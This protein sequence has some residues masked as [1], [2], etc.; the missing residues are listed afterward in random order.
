MPKYLPF[1]LSLLIIS[2]SDSP[3]ADSKKISVF[4]VPKLLTLHKKEVLEA[5]GTPAATDSLSDIQRSRGIEETLDFRRG[6]YE[7][8]LDFTPSTGEVLRG[9]ISL[10]NQ[11]NVD[12]YGLDSL[13]AAGNLDSL[14]ANYIAK[15]QDVQENG[16]TVYTG[17]HIRSLNE[18]GKLIK[19]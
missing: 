11:A 19:K 13:R 10:S 2:C 3:S 6:P 18:E 16:K 7:L 15:P 8:S 1:I 4:D 5:L 17:I 14:P 12:A 9:F